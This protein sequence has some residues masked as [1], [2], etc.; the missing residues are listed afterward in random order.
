MLVYLY[1]YLTSENLHLDV[2]THRRGDLAH[3]HIDSLGI[4]ARR[5]QSMFN[6]R[7]QLFL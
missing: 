3:M 5:H 7:Q 6:A 1:L 4:A 2:L